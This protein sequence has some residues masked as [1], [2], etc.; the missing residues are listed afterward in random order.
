MVWCDVLSSDVA[1][2]CVL[3]CPMVCH[4]M[5]YYC[6]VLSINVH[7]IALYS[8]VINSMVLSG[9]VLYAMVWYDMV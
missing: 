5:G 6:I 2:Y 8:G 9:M 1:L 4:G 7:G 3:L